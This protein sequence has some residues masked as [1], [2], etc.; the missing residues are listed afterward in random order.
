MSQF[1]M[2]KFATKE[3]RAEA[4][5]FNAGMRGVS[6]DN[7]VSPDFTPAE[8]QAWLNGLAR[9]EASKVTLDKIASEGQREGGASE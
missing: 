9:G 3:Q 4:M 7:D 1:A 2:S 8:Q 6:K 5:G